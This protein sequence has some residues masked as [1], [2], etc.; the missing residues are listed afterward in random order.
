ML[1]A[2]KAM[3]NNWDVLQIDAAIT[4]GNSGG[5]VLDET[6]HVVGVVT[7]GSLDEQGSMVQGMNFAIPVGIVKNFLKELGVK[8]EQGELTKQY[9]AAVEAFNQADY[10]AA[11]E[12]FCELQKQSP[13]FPYIKEFLD[14]IKKKLNENQ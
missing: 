2:R 13:D 4:H 11:D 7:F 3:E 1:S 12:Q 9:H 10:D 5:P 14:E 8:P 6:G